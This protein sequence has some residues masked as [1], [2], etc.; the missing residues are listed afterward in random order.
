MI[1]NLFKQNSNILT[2]VIM[3]AKVT[4]YK[5]I[6]LTSE[7]LANVSLIGLLSKISCS[8][9]ISNVKELTQTI[10]LEI[11]NFAGSVTYATEK[12][13]NPNKKYFT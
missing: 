1:R 3:I 8:I 6:C 5:I 13:I 7:N 4:Q 9:K 11:N 10:I 12:I 2:T